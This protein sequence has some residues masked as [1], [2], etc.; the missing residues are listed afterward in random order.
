MLWPLAFEAVYSG[1]LWTGFNLATFNIPIAN[2]PR[3][4]RTMYLA[5]FA[6]VSG[7]AFFASSLAGG[8]LAQTW[9]HFHWQVGPQTFINYHILFA[10]SGLFRLLAA[11]L[12]RHFHEPVE[13]DLP[14]MLQ[15]MGG[16]FLRLLSFGRLQLP[17]APK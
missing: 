13:K 1:A 3:E 8:V 7:L 12:I 6:V 2:S 4:G 17:W 15:F 11:L 5:A 9:I 14:T 10:I 16:A